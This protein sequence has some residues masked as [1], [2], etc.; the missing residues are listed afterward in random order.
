L[1]E[2]ALPDAAKAEPRDEKSERNNKNG[3]EARNEGADEDREREEALSRRAVTVESKSAR[4]ERHGKS[5]KRTQSSDADEP[6][7]EGDVVTEARGAT[8]ATSERKGYLKKRARCV[9]DSESPDGETKN[10]QRRDTGGASKNAGIGV[11]DEKTTTTPMLRSELRLRLGEI[12]DVATSLPLVASFPPPPAPLETV[13]VWTLSPGALEALRSGRLAAGNAATKKRGPR[14]PKLT[15]VSSV[16]G[17]DRKRVPSQ[18]TW[19]ALAAE[20][21]LI[22]VSHESGAS[23]GKASEN[24]CRRHVRTGPSRHGTGTFAR[25]FIP[26]GT[27]VGA[28]GGYLATAS[29]VNTHNAL[30]PDVAFETYAVDLQTSLD[31]LQLV[32]SGLPP[33]DSLLSYCNDGVY[34]APPLVADTKEEEKRAPTVNVAMV[35]ALW[36]DVLP[37]PFDIALRDIEEGEELL[38]D[39]GVGYWFH[40][41]KLQQRERQLQHIR[42]SLDAICV[43]YSATHPLLIT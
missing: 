25:C 42:S 12:R 24:P 23:L 37:L 13:G 43:G 19:D 33:Y 31:D 22:A 21:E 40:H 8:A 17:L 32:C 27:I 20:L 35:T 11:K 39:Y 1:K 38:K 36:D 10:A 30:C 14:V 16:A 5:R 18:A 41:L 7:S 34:S 26:A 6:E 28:Y 9:N 29:E 4:I 2:A 15:K 3:A